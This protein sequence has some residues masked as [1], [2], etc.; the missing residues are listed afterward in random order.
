MLSETESGRT[1]LQMVSGSRLTRKRLLEGEA[2]VQKRNKIQIDIW[3]ISTIAWVR[4]M[5]HRCRQEENNAGSRCDARTWSADH[6]NINGDGDIGRAPSFYHHLKFP[7]SVFD[8]PFLYS[9]EKR[10]F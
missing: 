6:Y 2:E 9:I 3:F 1:C 10:V 4:E 7:A 5:R 8:L